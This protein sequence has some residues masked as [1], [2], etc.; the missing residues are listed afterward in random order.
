MSAATI[1]KI[2]Q[3]ERRVTV[4]EAVLLAEALETTV[5]ENGGRSTG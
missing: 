3:Y 2:E 1:A 4:G 5:D